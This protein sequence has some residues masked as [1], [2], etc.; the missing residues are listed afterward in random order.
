MDSRGRQLGGSLTE[1]RGCRLAGDALHLQN[2]PA[3]PPAP[4]P[5]PQDT[6]EQGHLEIGLSVRVGATV[7]WIEQREI[8]DLQVVG[9]SNQ[10][11]WGVLG[12]GTHESVLAPRPRPEPT[13]LQTTRC[14]VGR[15]ALCGFRKVKLLLWGLRGPKSQPRCPGFSAE[16][17]SWLL[18]MS[19][20]CC[21]LLTSLLLSGLLLIGAPLHCC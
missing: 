15:S 19:A 1:L 9:K 21:L 11:S 14:R 5:R 17:R 16:E 20:G 4:S 6:W 12:K 3:P 13:A 2:R 8:C 10:C 7:E 18:C